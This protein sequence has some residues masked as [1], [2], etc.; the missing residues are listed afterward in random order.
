MKPWILLLL[1]FFSLPAIS[2]RAD[3]ATT[4]I[5][6]S[7]CGNGILDGYKVCDDGPLNGVYA[8]STAGRHCN[9]TCTGWAPYCGDNVVN[10]YFGEQCDDGTGNG[11][12]NDYCSLS[13]MSLPFPSSTPGGGGGNGGGGPG[14]S[15]LPGAITP[16]NPTTVVVEGSAYPDS[17][18]NILSNG[19]TIGIVKADAQ[20]NFR[21]STTNISPGVTTIGIWSEDAGGLKSTSV[22]VTLTVAADAVT[23]ISGAYLP[24]TV[25]LDKY[26]AAQGDIL[27]ASGQ[28]VPSTTVVMYINSNTEITTTTRADTGGNWKLPFSTAP[29]DNESFHTVRAS[30]QTVIGGNIVKSNVSQA[31]AFYVGTKKSGPQNFGIADLNHDGKVNL[32]DFSIMLYYWNTPGPVGDLNH[33]GKVG[34][35]DFSILLYYWTG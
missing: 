8:T 22:T 7:V 21:F 34:L 16:T 24:P 35:A 17:D 12:T 9:T 11:T 13:C 15:Y 19:T 31:V 28:S 3:T 14:G 4:T 1:I 32:A 6:I 27:T 18:V 33:D 25:T 5:F 2:A 10:P 26:K 29:L 23:T 20:A 30:F